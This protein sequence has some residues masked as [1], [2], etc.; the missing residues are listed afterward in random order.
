MRMEHADY[1][2][3]ITEHASALASTARDVAV[4]ATVPA[5]PEW[6]VAKLVRH[7]GT[8]HRW[9]AEVVRTRELLAPQQVDLAI[10]ED[11]RALPDWL[12]SSAA[13]LVGVLAA[14]DP[15]TPCWSWTDDHRVGFWSRR[16]AFETLVHARDGAGVAGPPPPFAP[17]LASDGIDEHLGN[18]PFVLGDAAAGD[19]AS[20]HVHCTDGAGEWLLRRSPAGLAVSR[21]H[22]KADVALRGRASDLFL[23]V[24]GRAAPDTVEVLGDPPAVATWRDLLHF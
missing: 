13:H 4:D 8:A 14:E 2:P 12:E 6:D 24:L 17:E 23:V 20:L 11:R 19:G 5:C 1:F 9:S 7:T 15:A 10:P 21:E 3:V 16:M 18:L 22:T